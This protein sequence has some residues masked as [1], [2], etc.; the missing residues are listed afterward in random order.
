MPTP[1]EEH[2]TE[3]SH[4]WS[5]M[6]RAVAAFHMLGSVGEFWSSD[7]NRATVG[8]A[9]PSPGEVLLDV[10]A[11][12]GPATVE[13]ASIVGARGT[14]IAVDPSRLMRAVLRLRI[15]SAPGRTIVDVRSGA[16]EALPVE[17]GSVDAVV[18]VNAVHHFDDLDVA[19]GEL[20]RV[21]RPGGRVILVEEDFA[22]SDHPFFST[23]GEEHGPHTVDPM[24]L[25]SKLADAGLTVTEAGPRLVGDVP[26]N[27]VVAKRTDAESE[28]G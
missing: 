16:A 28:T 3:G 2:A 27:V 14:V 21:V 18:A 6:H 5:I 13:A 1:H 22:Q 17:S 7:L 10:G 15:R 20:A 4:G 24:A 26:S 12:M 11:G 23:V 19:A 25:A 9:G 8:L